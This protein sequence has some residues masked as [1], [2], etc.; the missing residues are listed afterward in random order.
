MHQLREFIFDSLIFF[1]QHEFTL[2]KIFYLFIYSFYFWLPWVFLA[3]VGFLWLQQVGATL[4]L[5]WLLLLPSMGFRCASFSSVVHGLSCSSACG[6]FWDQ[7]LNPCPLHWLVDF[8]PL[9]HQGSCER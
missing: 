2:K 3:R 5:Q 7:E 8:Y 1:S 9:F 4:S 6:I